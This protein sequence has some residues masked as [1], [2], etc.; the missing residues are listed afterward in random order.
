MGNNINTVN[1]NVTL[2]NVSPLPIIDD[3]ICIHENSLKKYI[4]NGNANES[5]VK[6]Q[7]GIISK[8][9][10]VYNSIEKLPNL[11]YLLLIEDEMSRLLEKDPSITVFN[12]VIKVKSG[13]SNFAIITLNP[14]NDETI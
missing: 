1:K 14:F 2:E 13:K 6:I 12:I 4:N 3:L 7:N 11:E 5:Y 10:D 8:L 9:Y